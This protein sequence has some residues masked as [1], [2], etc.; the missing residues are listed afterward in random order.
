VH[1][2]DEAASGDLVVAY[3]GEEQEVTVKRYH[4][5]KEGI[6]LRPSNPAYK[7]IRFSSKDPGLRIAGKVIAILRRY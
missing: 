2:S 5:T 3:V 7:P 6:E 4:R 1:P